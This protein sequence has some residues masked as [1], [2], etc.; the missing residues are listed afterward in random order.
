MQFKTENI[1]Y[2]MDSIVL[3]YKSWIFLVVCLYFIS[4]N[5]ILSSSFTLLL[6][7][8][9][10]HVTHYTAH[11]K[12]GFP[13]NLVHLYHHDNSNWFS[14]FIQIVL[15]FVVL[16]Y[17]I[18]VKKMSEIYFPDSMFYK[19]FMYFIDEWVVLFSYIFYTT[20]HNINYSYFHVNHIHEEHHKLKMKNM[21]PDVCDVFFGTKE[22]VES[23]LENTDHY[24]PN[25]ICATVSVLFM[26]YIWNH[27]E[28]KEPYLIVFGVVFLICCILLLETV[29]VLY[30]Q[31]QETATKI[32]YTV[33]TKSCAKV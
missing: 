11:T 25:I 6:M 7:L 3:N 5:S 14:H 26:K 22:N 19:N 29:V 31:K 16:C 1:K 9:M 21:G 24:I 27:T 2:T 15:E 17:F 8:I 13:G 33:P 30:I 4:P 32:P 10:V 18:I 20:V 23:D 28:N 12:Y